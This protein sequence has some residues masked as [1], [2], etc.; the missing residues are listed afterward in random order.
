MIAGTFW[1][2]ENS[3]ADLYQQ[4]QSG[5]SNQLDSACNRLCIADSKRIYRSGNLQSLE[6]NV[7]AVLQ[8]MTGR[9]PNSLRSLLEMVSSRGRCEQLHHCLEQ[10][11][12]LK[13]AAFAL[14]IKA[15]VE[16]IQRLSDQ[17]SNTCLAAKVKLQK[18]E[19]ESVFADE[20]NHRIKEVGNK[21][22]LLSSRSL[23]LVRLLLDHVDPEH[24]VQIGCDKHG[25]RS[26]YAALIQHHLDLDF[27]TVRSEQLELSEYEFLDS[28][29]RVRLW[30][31]ARGESFL[32]TALSSMMAK[33]V[34]EVFMF[35]WNRFWQ[36][37]VSG[38][39]PTQG[40]PQDAR[41]FLRDIESARQN[42]N[43]SLE[44]IWRER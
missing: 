36:N 2:V 11:V 26:K 7:L 6:Q 40:Y 43:I 17:F 19:C 42:L 38:L 32:P 37:S 5:V 20:F 34:R 15:N 27:V 9:I 24:T 41:R 16:T 29:R 23:K 44:S 33:Y 21:A 18:V 39:K 35:A 22:N 13:D 8:S 4:L 28:G 3:E 25:G 12:W 30:F 31:A 1:T 10:Q 14:P